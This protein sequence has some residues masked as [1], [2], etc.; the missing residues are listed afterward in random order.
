MTHY[1]TK[2]SERDKTY[3]LHSAIAVA[4]TDMREI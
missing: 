4:L 2:F 1:V 3:F